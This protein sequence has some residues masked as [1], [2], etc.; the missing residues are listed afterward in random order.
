MHS[1]RRTPARSER[2]SEV[3]SECDGIRRRRVCRPT[4]TDWQVSLD[5][6]SFEQ[7]V[8][9]LDRPAVVHQGRKSPRWVIYIERQSSARPEAV[10]QIPYKAGM[11]SESS[12]P[13]LRCIYLWDQFEVEGRAAA[14]LDCDSNGK[15]NRKLICRNVDGLASGMRHQ[16]ED[17]ADMPSHGG[18]LFFWRLRRGVL[19]RLH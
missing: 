11:N 1:G 7:T 12:Y 16:R 18:T 2:Y 5:E 3:R 19:L 6:V 4:E 9:I 8:T 17:E 10:S 14:S 15:S 13:F